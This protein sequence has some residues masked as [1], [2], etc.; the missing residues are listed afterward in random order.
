MGMME[1]IKYGEGEKQLTIPS[2]MYR[3]KMTKKKGV[4][5]FLLLDLILYISAHFFHVN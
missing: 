5:V 2:A 3:G 4:V 1:R